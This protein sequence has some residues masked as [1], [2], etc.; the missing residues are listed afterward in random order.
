[1]SCFLSVMLNYEYPQKFII[2]SS[3]KFSIYLFAV[4]AIAGFF[5]LLLV[6]VRFYKIRVYASS[7][8]FLI[9]SVHSFQT[10]S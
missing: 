1:M 4:Y 3:N 10:C 9:T 7:I 6:A 2:I 8:I 5:E